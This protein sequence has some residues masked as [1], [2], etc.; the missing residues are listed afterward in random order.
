MCKW[1]RNCDLSLWTMEDVL[2][3]R[4]FTGILLIRINVTYRCPHESCAETKSVPLIILKVIS[5]WMVQHDPLCVHA[6]S[7]ESN[8]DVSICA[9]SP[10]RPCLDADQVVNTCREYQTLTGLFKHP[11]EGETDRG[12]GCQS[13]MIYR[14]RARERG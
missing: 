12:G 11:G 10:T 8:P 1:L 5:V 4:R 9:G 3:F 13:G 6:W 2:R 14:E 7:M